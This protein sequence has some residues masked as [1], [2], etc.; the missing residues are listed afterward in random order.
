MKFCWCNLCAALWTVIMSSIAAMFWLKI[1]WAFVI[2]A[3]VVLVPLIV[4]VAYK[5]REDIYF[6]AQGI[7]NEVWWLLKNKS[8]P[9]PK[10]RLSRSI[11][12]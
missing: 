2:P 9:E 11:P 3:A 12:T 8:G 6:T 10:R 1:S 5:E 7:V 4:V